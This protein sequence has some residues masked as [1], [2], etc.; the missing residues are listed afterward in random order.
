MLFDLLDGVRGR[1]STDQRLPGRP[2]PPSNL[3]KTSTGCPSR[4]P[5]PWAVVVI[6]RT[7]GRVVKSEATFD[8]CRSGA[9]RERRA[10]N[11]LT[12]P[13]SPQPSGRVTGGEEG[14]TE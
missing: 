10:A 12:L 14:T 13:R 8:A 6:G 1:V 2:R 5:W 7:G 11:A 3:G 4:T 9:T